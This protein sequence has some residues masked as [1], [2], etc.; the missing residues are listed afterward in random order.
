MNKSGLTF[1]I[2]CGEKETEFSTRFST[3][4]FTRSV[5]WSIWVVSFEGRGARGE[6][7]HMSGEGDGR[8]GEGVSMRL[9]RRVAGQRKGRASQI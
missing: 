3:R 7:G 5:V 6:L 4:F 9:G 2:I 1:L 8:S